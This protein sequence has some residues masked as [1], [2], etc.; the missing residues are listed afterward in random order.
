MRCKSIWHFRLNVIQQGCLLANDLQKT[1]SLTA[2]ATRA[3]DLI[4]VLAFLSGWRDMGHLQIL[5]RS[6]Q[7]LA[8]IV[9]QPVDS[10]DLSYKSVY[11][12]R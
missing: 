8:Q 1:A 4:G 12:G 2:S 9:Y 10:V 11:G 6:G 7:R 5:E 3:R